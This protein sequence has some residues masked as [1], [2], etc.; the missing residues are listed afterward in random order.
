MERICPFCNKFVLE[1]IPC[2]SC[3]NNMVDEGRAQEVLQDD[4]T[5]NM[6]INDAPSYCIHVFTCQV[7]RNSQKIQVSKIVV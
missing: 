3:G 4:Y 2:S 6:P 1:N 5:A 7:C